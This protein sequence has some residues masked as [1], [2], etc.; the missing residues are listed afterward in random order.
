MTGNQALLTKRAFGLFVKWVRLSV[1][2]WLILSW[3][4]PLENPIKKPDKNIQSVTTNT[5]S[6]F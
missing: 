1:W 5:D 3:N 6:D 2:L 4:A